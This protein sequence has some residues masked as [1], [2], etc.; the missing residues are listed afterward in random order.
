MK[1]RANLADAQLAAL[2]LLLLP[3]RFEDMTDKELNFLRSDIC[4]ELL[5]GE[6]PE[7]FPEWPKIEEDDV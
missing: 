5:Y 2:K 7:I 6:W 1:K 3:K 4:G